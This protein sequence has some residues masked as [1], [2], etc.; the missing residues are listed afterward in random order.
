M[1]YDDR[2]KRPAEGVDR[3]SKRKIISVFIAVILMLVFAM[4]TIAGQPQHLYESQQC[5]YICCHVDS[6]YDEKWRDPISHLHDFEE[7]AFH[8]DL[9]T[10]L[11]NIA[12]DEIYFVL[13][14]ELHDE[15][16]SYIRSDSIYM[17]MLHSGELTN[18]YIMSD[19]TFC[20]SCP[21][22]AISIRIAEVVLTDL[23]ENGGYY[24]SYMLYFNKCIRCDKDL[25]VELSLYTHENDVKANMSTMSAS[26]HCTVCPLPNSSTRTVTNHYTQCSLRCWTRHT[27]HT[28]RCTRC[29]RITSSS[30]VNTAF[31]PSHNW[32]QVIISQRINHGT[33]HPGNCQLIT[34]TA[35]RC[36]SCSFT[37]SNTRQ[38]TS[39]IWC[40]HPGTMSCPKM[41]Y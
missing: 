39:T 40:T 9:M 1:K 13:P 26:T 8:H 41:Q 16:L 38:S 18:I 29:D 23:S 4:P 36:S 7:L 24:N 37:S 27:T 32:R 35:D 22:P 28:Y 10:F 30:V 19:S 21:M 6:L 14:E 34:T 3:V 25:A 20:L 12:S 33:V 2:A 17:D 11:D 31:G 15:I 5:N